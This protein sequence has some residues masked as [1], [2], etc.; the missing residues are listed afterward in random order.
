MRFRELEQ[1]LGCHVENVLK[2]LSVGKIKTEGVLEM[3]STLTGVR[4]LDQKSVW[5]KHDVSMAV[6]FP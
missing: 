6:T 3:R 4:S 2:A 1:D 5:A